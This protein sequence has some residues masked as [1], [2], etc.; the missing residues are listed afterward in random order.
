MKTIEIKAGKRTLKA[1]ITLLTACVII[2]TEFD[3][4]KKSYSYETISQ[5]IENTT[6]IPVK[7]Y[8][9]TL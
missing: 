5:A 7:E 6:L 9:K 4:F 2:N 1:T 8:L 3:G